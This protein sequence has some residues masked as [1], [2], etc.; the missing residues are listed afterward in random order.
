MYA[1]D[2]ARAPLKNFHGLLLFLFL[3]VLSFFQSKPLFSDEPTLHLQDT[4][5]GPGQMGLMELEDG[6]TF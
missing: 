5:V 4:T 1:V 3:V 6:E 2:T